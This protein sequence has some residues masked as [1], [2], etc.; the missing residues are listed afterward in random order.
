M[1]PVDEPPS[2]R[3]A[4]ELPP[5]GRADGGTLPECRRG[6]HTTSAE[7]TRGG[8][9]GCKL[10]ARAHAV[11]TDDVLGCRP[12]TQ[13]P[14]MLPLNLPTR[15]KLGSTLHLTFVPKPA[16]SL[17]CSRSCYI[18]HRR[19]LPPRARCV[20]HCSRSLSLSLSFSPS[21][22]VSLSLTR[23]STNLRFTA[24]NPQP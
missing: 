19:C 10:R 13:I 21:L 12:T 8:H 4:L 18:I 23:R 15:N 24:P 3:E 9:R 7:V 11:E 20:I 22:P 14:R 1:V 6:E 16:L 2:E 17:G 5:R